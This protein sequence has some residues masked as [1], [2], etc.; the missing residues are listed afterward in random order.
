MT[1]HDALAKVGTD[2]ETQVQHLENSCQTILNDCHLG[3][4]ILTNPDKSNKF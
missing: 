2:V 1:Q 3:H 4:R